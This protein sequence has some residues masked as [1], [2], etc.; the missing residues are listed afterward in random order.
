MIKLLANMCAAVDLCVLYA[1][2]I[3]GILLVLTFILFMMHVASIF[4]IIKSRIIVRRFDGGPLTFQ[5]FCSDSSKLYATF[6]G[7]YGVI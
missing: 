6:F 4:L 1:T 5:R 7:C 2:C 3:G